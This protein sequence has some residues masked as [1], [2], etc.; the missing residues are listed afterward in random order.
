MTVGFDD[1]HRLSSIVYRLFT[2]HR[3]EISFYSFRY[4][5]M[6]DLCYTF[7][8]KVTFVLPGM[9]LSLLR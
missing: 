7:P 2:K 6:P 9:C 1:C 4:A 3:R 8:V 5:R